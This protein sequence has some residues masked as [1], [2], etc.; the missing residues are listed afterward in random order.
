MSVNLI[1]NADGSAGLQGKDLDPGEFIVASSRWD[2]SSV[3]HVFF[4]A[5]RAMVVQ[6]ANARVEVAGT[7]ASAVTAVIRKCP[8]GTAIASGTAIHS[9]SANLKGTA[10]TN[11]ALSLSTTA[12]TVALAAGDALAIA[13]TGTMTSATGAV[14][15]GL[16]PA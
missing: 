15:V 5:P 10:A 7:D 8:S 12:T 2:A 6:V 4:V 11:Q 9:G 14:S 16:T 3:S 13:F 1:Q